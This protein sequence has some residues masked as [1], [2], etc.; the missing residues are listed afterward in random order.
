MLETAIYLNQS[1]PL[2]TATNTPKR[3]KHYSNERTAGTMPVWNAQPIETAQNT[4]QNT[5]AEA[6]T[7]A[8]HNDFVSALNAS[9]EQASQ[10][11]DND[12]HLSDLIDIVNPLHHIPIIGTAYR[13]ITGDTIKSTAKLIGGTAF[14]G[15]LGFTSS[16]ADIVLEKETGANMEQHAFNMFKKTTPNIEEEVKSSPEIALNEAA[17]S[18]ESYED[19]SRTLLSFADLGHDELA[20]ELAK[21]EPGGRPEQV[22][23]T[24][25]TRHDY[26]LN[27]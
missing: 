19:I 27:N 17:T 14:G 18:K 12:F 7:P 4:I 25:R 24:N 20:I 9:N 26:S 23:A 21:I 13:A 15:P 6:E 2:D 1:N 3:F 10:S 5:L 8:Q 11:T 22:P 16:L